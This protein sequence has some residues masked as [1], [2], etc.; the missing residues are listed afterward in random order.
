[1]NAT[2]I[3]LPLFSLWLLLIWA[4]TRHVRHREERERMAR[5]ERLDRHRRT[6]TRLDV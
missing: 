1:M 4:G 5:V 3:I 2:Q 6:I